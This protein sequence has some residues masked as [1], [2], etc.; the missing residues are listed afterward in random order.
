MGHE[1]KIMVAQHQFSLLLE[2]GKK[3]MIEK[4]VLKIMLKDPVP[5]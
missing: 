3:K 2:F 1:L 4:E 5:C